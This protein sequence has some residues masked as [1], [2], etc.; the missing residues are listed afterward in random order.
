MKEV[1][2]K[3]ILVICIA[4][5]LVSGFKIAKY[6]YDGHVVQKDFKKLEEEYNLKQLKE[7]NGDTFAWLK[8]LDTKISY[9]VM[10]TPKSPEYYLRRN[11]EKKHSMAGTP[12][13]DGHTNL[14]KSKHMI[15]YGHHMKDGTMFN[16]LLN[17][18]D[19]EY[20]KAHDTIEVDYVNGGK[21]TDRVFAYGKTDALKKGFNVYD[22]VNIQNKGDFNAYIKGVKSMTKKDT[23]ITPKWGD[24]IITLSTCSYHSEEGRYVVVAVEI[25]DDSKSREK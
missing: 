10:F 15:F 7:K 13:L 22:Y 23:G 11:F 8:V 14:K 3:I 25:K 19:P 20:A 6:Y 24:N 17:Y 1:I 12:F 4:V 2:R 21:K 16:N 18:D 9:P 5:F